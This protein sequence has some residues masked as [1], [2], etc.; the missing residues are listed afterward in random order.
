MP[1]QGISL[2]GKARSKII[3]NDDVRLCNSYFWNRFLKYPEMNYSR[4]LNYPLV[5]RTNTHIV[6]QDGKS[7]KNRKVNC[8][9]FLRKFQI[10]LQ[11]MLSHEL[12]NN[13]CTHCLS[14]IHSYSYKRE[15]PRK[16][17]RTI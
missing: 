2:T 4:N 6:D 17:Y 8:V 1:D 9:C 12:Y 13:T 7:K 11:H 14:S 3:E 10:V 15:R 5:L 16:H